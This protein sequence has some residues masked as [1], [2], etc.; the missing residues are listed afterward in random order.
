MGVYKRDD[1]PY[2]HVWLETA[3]KG[4]QRMRTDVRIGTT[5][6]TFKESKRLAEL[7]YHAEMG[8]RA[9]RNHD[10]PEA[11]D[12]I[13]FARFAPWWTEHRLPHRRG[14][15]R[16][17]EILPRLV[18]FFGP[19]ELRAITPPVVHEYV[20]QRL[21]TPTVISKKKRTAGRTVNASPATV[22]REIDLLKALL[23]AAKPTYL[24]VSP[25]FGMP[26]LRT[27]TPKRRIMTEDEERRLLA[28]MTAEDRALFLIGLDSLVRLS[29][30]LDIKHSDRRGNKLWIADPKANG[31]YWLPLSTR[32]AAALDAVKTGP[33]D[34]VFGRRRIARTER[35]RRNGIRQ[36]LERYCAQADPPIPF[37]RKQDGLTFHWATRRTGATRMLTRNVDPGTVQKIG[38]W[39]T[40]DVVLGIYHELID[41]KAEEAVNSV[42]P[43]VKR[44]RPA[45]TLVRRKATR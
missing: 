14:A 17:R 4:R 22:N 12:R 10:L 39:K 20:T 1:S 40:A 41:S 24:D 45:D 31:G 32:A 27:A 16:E 35:D 42:A 19:Y 3:P 9:L 25:L 44:S 37:G 33:S 21:K 5:P 43:L 15:D 11:K 8:K 34:Y 2:W 28:V 30:I 38:R 36:M 26:R 13:T 6:Q 23:Q 7:V 18:A 29:D